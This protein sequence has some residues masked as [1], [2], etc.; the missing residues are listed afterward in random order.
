[1]FFINFTFFPVF[2]FETRY[3][4]KIKKE[5]ATIYSRSKNQKKNKYHIFFL[6]RFYKVN[7]KDQGSD[8]IEIFIILDI[9][10]SLIEPDIENIDVK[11]QLEHQTQI[12]ETKDSGW[13]VDKINSMRIGFYKTSDLNG[14]NSVKIPLRSNS[15]LNNEK[16]DKFCSLWSPL[17]Y[18]H[19]SEI[20]HPSRVG[21]YRQNFNEINFQDFDVTNSFNFS[22]VYE[23]EKLNNLSTK[24]FHLKFYQDQNKWK[25]NLI[26]YEVCKNESK[27]Y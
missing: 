10:H 15:I 23:L 8:G 6:G 12:Q 20:D 9:N 1:M 17:F 27:S 24:I 5:R 13:M 16:N 18:L 4:N 22:D 21:K 25:H 11:S 14:S 26:P 2:G 3:T 7:E 19:P